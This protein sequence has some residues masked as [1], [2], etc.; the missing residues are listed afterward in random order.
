MKNDQT[1]LTVAGLLGGGFVVT[2][3]G[4]GQDGY[5]IFAQR[6]NADGTKKY[7]WPL[8]PPTIRQKHRGPT[9]DRRGA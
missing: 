4:D 9:A 1:Q 5:G 3:T 7:K 8:H 2:S 6:F